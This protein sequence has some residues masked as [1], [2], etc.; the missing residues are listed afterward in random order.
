[1]PIG[2]PARKHLV[3]WCARDAPVREYS[4][5]RSVAARK[6]TH[7]PTRVGLA[8]AVHPSHVESIAS[9]GVVIAASERLSTARR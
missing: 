2:A 7:N 3:E 6:H 9:I 8:T 5:S 1:M 4:Y